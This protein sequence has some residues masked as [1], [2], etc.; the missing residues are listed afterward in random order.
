MTRT[1][2]LTSF[3]ISLCVELF[4]FNWAAAQEI[5]KYKHAAV[6]CA[7]PE[8]AR[9]GV[10]IIKDGGN[11]VDAAIA[12]QFALAVV[13]PNA[14]NIGGGGFMMYRSKTGESDA[15]DYRETAPGKASRDMY[16]DAKGNPVIDKS[17]LG[18]LASGVPGSV[19]GM[20]KAHNK[21]GKLK[22]KKDIQPAI[23]LA[24]KGFAVTAQQAA[25]LN[26]H[27]AD[28]LK[29]NSKPVAFVKEA[30]WK[31]G[32]LLKQ[33]QLA[34]TLKLIRDKGRAG[35][36]EGPVA[37]AIVAAM[38]HTQGI[39]SEQDLKEYKS[40][41]RKP[42]SGS[43]Q[44]YTVISM[45][46]PSSGGIALL[47]MLKQVGNYPLSRWGFQQD[48]TVQLMV[49]VERRAYADR[50]SYLGDPDF[51]KVPQTAL[52]D[53]NY[54]QSRIKGLSFE[55]ATLST[56][57]KPG[58]LPGYE[59][60]QTTHY[61]IVDAEG[62]AV[63]ATTTLNGSY[64]SLVVVDGAGFILNN[65]MDDF[66]VKPGSPNMYGLIGGEAN[67]IYAGK[68]MLSSM[69]PTIIEKDGKLLMV[70]GTP[71]GSTI[72]TSVFQTV[73]N[74]LAFG[75]GMQ[76]AVAAPRFHHQWLPD[77]VTVEKGAIA[78][79][80]RAHLQ[81]KGYTFKER[82]SIGRVDAILVRPDGELETG[83][84]PRGNDTASGF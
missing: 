51:F 46:P 7:H 75:Q 21:Y 22:W 27:K 83:A 54:I 60:E 14:G 69:T 55:K 82:G 9:V 76:A 40:V 43:Y 25:E 31:E 3:A 37:A 71:G 64:G 39:I 77:D 44:N 35:F 6:V 15:L 26:R 4:S 73:L 16:L 70:V 68:R 49:E 53:T 34:A 32:D 24:E 56:D 10:A 1:I 17:L 59:S 65:E 2:L 33:P 28:F 36:Y 50:A 61:S 11:A 67:S 63:S 78:P 80:A 48:S 5:Q 79:A 84:D 12:V 29:Y 72:I 62:N 30:V 42:V 52:L 13:Y 57:V 81:V 45:P 18:A 74:V 23:D 38:A 66:S 41:W 47:T 19:D 58:V 20:V 8:A